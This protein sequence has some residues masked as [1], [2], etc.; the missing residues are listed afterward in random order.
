MQILAEIPEGIPEFLCKV[1]SSFKKTFKTNSYYLVKIYVASCK[2][3]LTITN[4]KD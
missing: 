4:S 2:Y 1:V 3:E